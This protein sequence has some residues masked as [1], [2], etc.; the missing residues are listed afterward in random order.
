LCLISSATASYAQLDQDT[1][2]LPE[3]TITGND[4]AA[5]LPGGKLTVIKTDSLALDDMSKVLGQ[6]LPVYFVQYGAMGQLSSINLRGL[7]AAR[8]NL[9]WQGMEINSFTVGQSDFGELSAGVAANIEIQQGAVS[10]LYGNGALGGSIELTD[11]LN[12]HRGHQ[13]GLNT[14]IGS[15]GMQGVNLGY[16][17]ANGQI[18]SST[19]LFRRKSDNDFRYKLGTESQRQRNAG[20]LHYGLIQHFQYNVNP[21]NQLSFHLWYNDYLREVQPN[22]FDQN[23]DETLE[24]ENLRMTLKWQW[25]SNHSV[26]KIQAGYTHDYQLYDGSELIQVYRWFGSV[27]N[28]W[29]QIKNTRIRFGANLNYLKP[30]VDAYQGGVSE[31]RSDIYGSAVWNAIPNLS[32]ALSLRT[33]MVNGSFKKLLPMVSAEYDLLKNTHLNW[34]ADFQMGTS[35]RLPTLNDRYW[36]PGGNENLLP[37]Y[38]RNLELGMD[39]VLSQS[40]LVWNIGIRGFRHQVDNWIIWIPGGRDEGQ[41][42]E[43]TSFWFPDNIRE[44]LAYG[45]EYESAVDWQLPVPNLSS[46]IAFNGIYN[47]SLNKK[48]ISP[49]DRSVDKQLPYTPVNVVNLNWT[50]KYHSWYTGITGQY[51]SKRYVETNNELPALDAFILWNVVA[52]KRGVQGSI[53]WA[54]ELQVNN[55]TSK[56]YETFENRAM[57]GCNYAINLSINFNKQT[58]LEV[59]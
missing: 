38:S 14:S 12:L 8:T 29:N 36:Y 48:S 11:V 18:A 26:G 32:L 56:D 20:F 39:L 52:G 53:N 45:F 41:N 13:L 51:R 4:P 42:G 33:P 9:T 30:E 40:N 21:Q 24:S 7:G 34:S 58:K 37:E 16:Q 10:P 44:V 27:E 22:K 50:W 2:L 55:I 15:Y 23:S 6:Y 28:E 59:L 25:L 5:Y 47:R 17:Y 31:Y 46:S 43:I 35:F 57:P 3:I 1:L 49:V 54:L 19:K